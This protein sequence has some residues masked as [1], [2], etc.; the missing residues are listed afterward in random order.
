MMV[1][2]NN[3]CDTLRFMVILNFKIL[4]RDIYYSI[5][6]NLPFPPIF[7]KSVIFPNYARITI[8]CH[9]PYLFYGNGISQKYEFARF[10]N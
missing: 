3:I 5:I 8:L 4:F 10:G 9:F 6:Y 2:S 1:V 7:H